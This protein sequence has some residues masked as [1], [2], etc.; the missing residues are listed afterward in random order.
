MASLKQNFLPALFGT[1]LALSAISMWFQFSTPTSPILT[2]L[3]LIVVG[4][5]T[6]ILLNIRSL[7]RL[8]SPATLFTW[9]TV[10]TGFF[11][12]VATLF[13]VFGFFAKVSLPVSIMIL[14]LTP[15]INQ[16]W[17]KAIWGEKLEHF[18]RLGIL[19]SLM[20]TVA[21]VIVNWKVTSGATSQ[22]FLG[23]AFIFLG[24]LFWS[25]AMILVRTSEY[26]GP[27]VNFWALACSFT[28]LFA[29][30]TLIPLHILLLKSSTSVSSLVF[31]WEHFSV[32]ALCGIV[33][34]SFRFQFST[35]T[36]AQLTSDRV[37]ILWTSAAM[38]TCLAFL[39]WVTPTFGA[40]NLS[41]FFLQILGLALGRTTFSQWNPYSGPQPQR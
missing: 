36:S 2:T 12:F 14:C 27:C 7:L 6:F 32:S 37:G 17:K 16:F 3:A 9:R 4:A 1:L 10:A 33:W 26:Q 20:A 40:L 11:I 39:Y 23:P 22:L 18:Q 29:V 21:S 19:I 35:E 38:L 30:P 13:Y 31:S 25:L 34:L 24:T 41:F 15:V 8:T 28:C 5:G